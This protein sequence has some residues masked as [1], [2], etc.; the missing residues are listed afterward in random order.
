VIYDFTEPM[1]RYGTVKKLMAVQEELNGLGYS[2]L[3]WDG[4][5]PPYAQ[6]KLWEIVP[7]ANFVANPYNGYSSHSRGNT[8]DVTL[9]TLNGESV[10]MPSDFDEFAAIADRDYS[11]VSETA[12][13]NAQLLETVMQKHGFTGYWNEWWHYSDTVSY[14]AEDL[15]TGNT[16]PD[17]G[18]D[19][20]DF[21]GCDL[22]DVIGEV[23]SGYAETYDAGGRCI[24]YSDIPAQFFYN[25]SDHVV[26]CIVSGGTQ[27]VGNGL[28]GKMTYTEIKDAVAMPLPEAEGFY[29]ELEGCYEYM[30]QFDLDG[31]HVAFSWSE[32]PYTTQSSYITF[33]DMDLYR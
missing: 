18:T 32:D 15:L 7:D 20:F 21:I 13:A 10:E 6:F 16:Q 19:W 24:Y 30:L 3:I 29:N 27:T 31:I 28:N 25:E 8:V 33:S 17:Q 4:Y 11:D 14:E 5:R 23:G 2:L 26:Y 1:L 12:K 22:N 9:V